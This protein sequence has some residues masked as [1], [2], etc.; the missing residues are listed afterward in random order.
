MPLLL[1]NGLHS[2]AAV[3]LAWTLSMG[4][5]G[6]LSMSWAVLALAARWGIARLETWVAQGRA[7]DVERRSI[8]DLLGRALIS[9]S[10]WRR[11]QLGADIQEFSERRGRFSAGAEWLSRALVPATA[12]VLTAQATVSPY[13][14]A[15][16]L[17]GVGLIPVFLI[18]I[19][20]RTQAASDTQVAQLAALS[21]RVM[22]RLRGLS[23]LW[24][25]GTTAA[26]ARDIEDT[27]EQHRRATFRVLRIAF[28]SNASVDLVA[29]LTIALVAVHVGTAL[30]GLVGFAGLTRIDLQSGLFI[31]MLAP[32]V[33][34]PWRRLTAAWHDRSQ[35]QGAERAIEQWP[36]NTP[37]A[38]A[39]HSGELVI[40]GRAVAA[41]SR[42]WIRG[43]SGAGKSQLLDALAGLR[44]DDAN[45][46][47]LSFGWLE[48]HPTIRGDSVRAQLRHV[49]STWDAAKIR[50][51]LDQL[52]LTARVGDIDQ[53]FD[54]LALSGGEHQ[55]LAL[56]R[57]LSRD[58]AVLLMDEPSASLDW[59]N[60][61]VLWD[62][63]ERFE[64]TQVIASHDDLA[65]WA[66]LQVCL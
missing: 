44:D 23:A 47:G 62:C 25:Q 10:P 38:S 46:C 59:A 29:S 20:S 30:L 17:I 42:V 16:M 13:L 1:I 9:A 28:L 22:E 56:L 45:F 54:P 7:R 39:V 31:L 61:Q 2:A 14:A 12:I 11:P 50:A 18:L 43:A 65:D 15:L 57:A 34:L 60:A 27:S 41:G 64:G 48:Q 52:G 35:A 4:L 3:A 58:P 33:V 26:A 40:Q 6:A 53:P 66:S 36:P 51:M 24:I 5:T 8:Q 49:G 37:K 21:T 19:G 55:R 63:L 32:E